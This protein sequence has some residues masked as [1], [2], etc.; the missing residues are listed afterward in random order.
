MN[1]YDFKESSRGLNGI[2]ISFHIDENLAE[3][4]AFEQIYH[5]FLLYSPSLVGYV[6]ITGE[7]LRVPQSLFGVFD[8]RA[9]HTLYAAKVAH[10]YS[11][12][13]LVKY[14]DQSLIGYLE[15]FARMHSSKIPLVNTVRGGLLPYLQGPASKLQKASDALFELE[16]RLG[17]GVLTPTAFS[18]GSSRE[19]LEV[20]HGRSYLKGVINLAEY[21]RDGRITKDQLEEQIRAK[22]YLA[23][24]GVD[25]VVISAVPS[26]VLH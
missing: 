16:E 15:T 11:P 5:D 21:V 1:P 9:F 26:K 3:A 12:E 20:G 7:K 6:N 17:Y 8:A 25:E 13:E 4:V 24:D 10:D 18:L 14:V 19:E 22:G 23:D 2:G